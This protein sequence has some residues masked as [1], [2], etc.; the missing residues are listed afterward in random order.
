MNLDRARRRLKI[1][2]SRSAPT[3]MPSSMPRRKPSPRQSPGVPLGVIRN[4]L[5][6][7]APACRC[8]QYL[9]I[10]GDDG[11]GIGSV[12]E[13]SAQH[14]LPKRQLCR[15]LELRDGLRRVEHLDGGHAHL[16]RGLQIDAEIVKIDAVPGIDVQRLDHHLVDARV[17]LSEADLGR[18]R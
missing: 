13:R 18:T 10:A 6:A 14:D 8:A 4:L 9:E 1:A 11:D 12:S 3:S 16:A 5:T 7:R 15:R 2:S 17:G